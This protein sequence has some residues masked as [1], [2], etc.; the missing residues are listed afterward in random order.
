[1][2][3][4]LEAFYLSLKGGCELI[5]CCNGGNPIPALFEAALD[6]GDASQLKNLCREEK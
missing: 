1:M 6:Q 3:V 5:F 2:Q 4:F